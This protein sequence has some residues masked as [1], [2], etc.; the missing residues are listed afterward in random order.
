MQII[1][2]KV[3]IFVQTDLQN[4]IAQEIAKKYETEDILILNIQQCK[5]TFENKIYFIKLYGFVN[6]IK[7]FF[8]FRNN[9]IKFKCDLLI[10]NLLT[11]FNSF[12]IISAFE[13]SKLILM[14]DGIGTPVI[15]KHPN[16]YS[17]TINYRIKNILLKI[18]YPFFFK[19]KFKL[20]KDFLPDISFY[21]TIYNFK[22]EIPSEQI[23]IFNESTKILYGH[24][25]FIGQPMIE[26]GLISKEKYIGFLNDIIKKE[27]NIIY[28][29]HPS[30]SFLQMVH[31]NGLTYVQNRLPIEK[32]FEENG[33]P[34][35]VFSFY[36]SS[37]LN[38]KQ[39]NPKVNFYY[40][41]N[42]F[43]I[44]SLSIFA[45][46]RTFLELADIKEYPLSLLN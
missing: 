1:E 35:Y 37:L 43:S 27:G 33:I 10:G 22:N 14:D 32:E 28:Y 44:S 26:F 17:S 23:K 34:E 36:S 46:Y 7:T 21:F 30:E 11:N 40:I 4:L 39:Q 29:G 5:F 13:Y 45:S 41:P 20:I 18:L 19:E 24:K 8:V 25:C 12:F 9:G 2:K 3:I 42:N 16:Y 15:L 6:I 38:L 31:I